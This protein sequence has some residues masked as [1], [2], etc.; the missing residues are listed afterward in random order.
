MSESVLRSHAEWCEL[1]DEQASS[2]ESVVAF[3][4]ARS[5]AQHS[6]YY[7]KRRRRELLGGFRELQVS[8]GG[9][10]VRVVM[11]ACHVEVDG[12]FDASCLR[13]VVEALR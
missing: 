1:I 8:P 12:G 13:A 2:G 3:C 5:L 10:G 7:H 9:S 4:E 6:F 11:G